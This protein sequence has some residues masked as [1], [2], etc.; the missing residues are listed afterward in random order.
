MI[1]VNQH[2]FKTQEQLISYL[3]M[4][5]KRYIDYFKELN[6]DIFDWLEWGLIHRN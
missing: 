3:I 6:Y 5:S 4:T 1:R 2:T